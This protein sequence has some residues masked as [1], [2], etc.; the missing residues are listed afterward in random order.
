M[1]RNVLNVLS[2]ASLGMLL[3]V[4]PCAQAITPVNSGFTIEW[5][6]EQTMSRIGTRNDAII[7]GVVYMVE[8]EADDKGEDTPTEP[9][10]KLPKCYECP[11][12]MIAEQGGLKKLS[13][14]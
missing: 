5:N 4:M 11:C 8:A 6:N 1:K 10:E 13:I 9:S 3:G 7:G 2:A 14:A 12:G